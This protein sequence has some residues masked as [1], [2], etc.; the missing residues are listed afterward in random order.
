VPSADERR[1]PREGEVTLPRL[2]ELLPQGIAPDVPNLAAA[3][4]SRFSSAD[5]APIPASGRT[6]GLWH[7][8]ALWVG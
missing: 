1:E 6:W 5:L 3:A 4:P 2:S 8:A 7:Y